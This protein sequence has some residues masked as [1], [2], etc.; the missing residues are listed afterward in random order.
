MWGIVPALTKWVLV[1]QDTSL[2]GQAVTIQPS[3]GNSAPVKQ[4]EEDKPEAKALTEHGDLRLSSLAIRQ[5]VFCVITTFQLTNWEV[6]AVY[7]VCV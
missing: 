5:T 1:N 3:T 6:R 4:A 2:G 7:E